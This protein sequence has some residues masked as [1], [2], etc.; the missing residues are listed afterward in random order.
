MTN[1]LSS[2]SK[3]VFYP[4]ADFKKSRK[5]RWLIIKKLSVFLTVLCILF[6]FSGTFYAY[7]ADDLPLAAE[8]P[9]TA[10]SPALPSAFDSRQ[11]NIVPPVR[12]QGDSESCW[13]F[14]AVSAMEIDA[15]KQGLLSADSVDFSEAHLVW[16][17]FTPAEDENDILCGESYIA[18]S[19][20]Y[21][22]R[23]NWTRATGTLARLSGAANEIDFPFYAESDEFELMGNYPEE[24]RYISD[25]IILDETAVLP[26][27]QAVKEWITLHGSCTAMMYYSTKYENEETA[28]YYYFGSSGNINHMITIVGW[29]DNYPASAFKSDPEKNGAWLVRDSRGEDSHNDGY[30]YLSYEDT[31]LS[32]FAGYSVRPA[33]DFDSRYTY[34]AVG[35]SPCF[36]HSN[37]VSV[38]NVF[39]T[40]KRELLSALSFYTVDADTAADV[41]VY[42]LP[43]FSG[44]D[45]TAGEMIFSQSQT[46]HYAGYHTLDLPEAADLSPDTVFSVVITYSTP[47]K[48]VTVPVEYCNTVNNGCRYTSA[49]GQ[50]FC[51]MFDKTEQWCDSQSLGLGN[52]YINA[53]TCEPSVDSTDFLAVFNTHFLKLIEIVLKIITA[54]CGA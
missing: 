22:T 47:G 21:V 42:R 28:S 54:V 52:F 39:C 33:S 7:A 9:V 50:S 51:Y 13:A 48:T 1:L 29:D 35:F 11:L 36:Q 10:G 20:P 41:A 16:F 37:G 25:D 46:Y 24:A 19:S 43:D 14:A 38:A 12:N 31:S 34:N 32:T 30:F 53:Y 45:P 4:N 3:R 15:V 2:L 6:M 44:N 5:R 26:S 17:T 18:S 40:E 49:D 27:A 8:A 23:G